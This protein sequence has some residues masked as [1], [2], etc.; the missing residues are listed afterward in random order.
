VK[1]IFEKIG[2][3]RLDRVHFK[4]FG[5]SSLDFEVVYYVSSNEYAVYMDTQQVVNFEL[6]EVFE[7]EKIEFAYPTQTLYVKK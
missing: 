7:K 1:G 6:F 3:A 4:N 2:T 5:D